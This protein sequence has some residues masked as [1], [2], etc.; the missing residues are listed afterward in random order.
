MAMALRFNAERG[1]G[2]HVVHSDIL[3]GS[4]LV[5]EKHD[6]SGLTKIRDGTAASSATG[7]G[8]LQ[9]WFLALLAAAY[10]YHLG[11][12]LEMM[13]SLADTTTTLVPAVVTGAVAEMTPVGLTREIRLREVWST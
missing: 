3:L 12:V 5:A 2:W 1:H 8:I 6:Q 4:A 10:R 11:R 7:A 13:P 9:P